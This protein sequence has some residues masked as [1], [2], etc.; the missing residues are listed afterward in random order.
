MV[1]DT[2]VADEVDSDNL[3]YINRVYIVPSN[4]SDIYIN[5]EHS[6]SFPENYTTTKT[7][8]NVD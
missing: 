2:V 8:T 6:D 5:V 1:P 3:N 4:I 7:K